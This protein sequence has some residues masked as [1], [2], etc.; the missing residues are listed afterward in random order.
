MITTYVLEVCYMQGHIS[1]DVM[2]GGKGYNCIFFPLICFK[3]IGKS[4]LEL[5]MVTTQ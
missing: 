2:V 3:Q 4:H 5:S 1:F